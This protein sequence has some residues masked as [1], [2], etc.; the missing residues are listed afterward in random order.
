MAHTAA[1]VT[2]A[3]AAAMSRVL[4][5]TAAIMQH[6]GVNSCFESLVELLEVRGAELLVTTVLS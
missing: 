6:Q 3:A 4:P 1:A 2:A 5:G